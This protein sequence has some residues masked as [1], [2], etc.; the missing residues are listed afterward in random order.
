[1]AGRLVDQLAANWV[2]PKERKLAVLKDVP[3]GFRWVLNLVV[4]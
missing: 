2:E 1:M 4:R 3:L